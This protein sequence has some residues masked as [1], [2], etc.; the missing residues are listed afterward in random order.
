MKLKRFFVIPVIIAIF[1][2]AACSNPYLSTE[3][4]W[5][6]SASG[7]PL[8]TYLNNDYSAS[9]VNINDNGKTAVFIDNNELT[10][11]ITAIAETSPAGYDDVVRIVN[12]E[13]ET[14]ISMFFHKDQRFPWQIH[15][16]SDGKTAVGLLSGYNWISENFSIEFD[17][18]GQKT[19][20]SDI[21]LKQ[22]VLLDYKFITSLNNDQNVRIRNIHTALGIY[23]SLSKKFMD[24]SKIKLNNSSNI[25]SSVFSDMSIL[26]FGVSVSPSNTIKHAAS[27]D[28]DENSL[29]FF[30][31]LILNIIFNNGSTPAPAPLEVTIT[32]D[33]LPVNSETIYYLEHHEEIIFDFQF[34]NFTPNT[35]VYAGFY[36]PTLHIYKELNTLFYS[37]NS[38]DNL[39]LG[40]FTK[41]YQIKIKRHWY[42]G[43]G[44]FD[45]TSSLVIFFG[46]NT[47]IN[48]NNEG[49]LF[50]EPGSTEAKNNK[51]IFIINLTVQQ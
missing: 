3:S 17:E 40:K 30:T 41:N 45:G 20:I 26:T 29:F 47:I 35:N 38:A 25:I 5:H 7:T 42:T 6:L 22:N 13:T 39:P 12:N 43:P 49:I 37:F 31:I 28:K 8:F 34:N 16:E 14:V 10:N 15:I 2:L 32:K 23:S 46:Q 4:Y 51:S 9:S 19:L 24:Y 21:K 44:Y 1:F 48:G 27:Y 18:N 36:D 11:N 50:H 33:G